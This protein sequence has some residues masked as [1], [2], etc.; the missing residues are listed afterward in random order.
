MSDRM[1][2]RALLSVS[3][4][5]GL[6]E[7]A[8]G[9]AEFGVALISTGGT[10]KELTAAG[11]KVIDI[12]EVT[13]FPEMLDGRV[14]TLHPRIHGGILAVRDDP[15]HTATLAEHK[16]EPIDLVV[17]NLYPFEQ[18]VARPGSTRDE[19]IENIDIGGPSLIRAAA[20]NHSGVA[21]VTGPDQYAAV[22]DEMRANKG[23]L[24]QPTRERLMAAAF[25][26]TAAYDRAIA[27]YFREGEAPAEPRH[28]ARQEPRPP[29]QFPERLNLSFTKKSACATARTRIR[30]RRFTSNRTTRRF[31]RHCGNSEWQRTLLQQ[32]ARSR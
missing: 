15:K 30:K 14:K 10:R 20:K 17:V 18:T 26:R 6:V 9:L 25:A 5:A 32:F 8:R 12:S 4:K 24:G 19:I 1:I 13:G 21:V 29:D 28:S 22:L 16:I 27:D 2:R 3:D 7:F 23:A 31:R 11:L